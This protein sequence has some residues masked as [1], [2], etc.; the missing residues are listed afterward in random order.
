VRYP[1]ILAGGSGTRL[2]PLSHREMPKQLLPL[3]KDGETLLAAA[4]RRVA[5]VT[6]RRPLVI[7]T[8]KFVAASQ[9]ALTDADYVAEPVGRNTAPALALAAALLL[10]RDP[11]AIMI[12]LPADQHIADEPEFERIVVSACEAVERDDVI[13][14]IGIVPTRPETGY[15]YLE[16]ASTT[17]STVVPVIRFVEKPPIDVAARYVAEKKHLWNAGIFVVSARR[18]LDEITRHQ[19]A[20]AAGIAQIAA[21][22]SIGEQ[23]FADELARVYP[24]LPSISIDYAVMERTDRVATIAAS[25]GW[26][27]IGSWSSV[28]TMLGRDDQ[29]NSCAG[30]T[31]VIDGHDN[32]VVSERGVVAVLG[33]DRLV[34]VRRG[35]AVLV[36]PVERAQ[37]VRQVVDTLVARGL[38]KYL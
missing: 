22:A 37:D 11:K 33:C 29:R 7:T 12:S 2:W 36:M 18:L 6:A 34:V 25:V 35:D 24:T 27:D 21:A 23:A 15:G 4:A 13:C 8:T 1:V 32:V 5:G 31:I 14:T 17:A 9:R 16:V 30:N 3:G 19:P 38:T 20:L 10:Q 28:P 26:D